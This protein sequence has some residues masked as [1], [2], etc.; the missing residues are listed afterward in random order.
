MYARFIVLA[1][2]G[3]ALS[4]CASVVK[5]SSEDIAIS[6]PPTTGAQCHLSNSVGNWDVTSPGTVK[7]E[8]SKH[9]MTVECQKDGWQK[10][11]AI[12]PSDWEGWTLGNLI[13]GGLIGVGVDAATGA[14]NQYPHT[15][16]VPMT[17]EAPPPAPPAADQQQAP[18]SGAAVPSNSGTSPAS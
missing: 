10:A 16:Q 11:S 12:I 5:G 14:I 17:P 1:C 2:V 13:L 4:G 15:F 6:T 3:V 9:D 7:V 8:R 18:A